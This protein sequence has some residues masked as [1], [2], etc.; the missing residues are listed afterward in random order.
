MEIVTVPDLQIYPALLVFKYFL[1]V[2]K[3]KVVIL[4]HISI[5]KGLFFKKK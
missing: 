2:F 5:L 4:R 3:G 1:K